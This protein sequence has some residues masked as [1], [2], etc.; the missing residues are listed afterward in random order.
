MSGRTGSAVIRRRRGRGRLV[1][2]T[3]FVGVAATAG[4]S[5]E[6]RC[7]QNRYVAAGTYERCQ[8]KAEGKYHG[9]GGIDVPRYQES[10]RKCGVVYARMLQRLQG[11]ALG[12][13]S[14]CDGARLVDNGD[15]TVTD[16][17]TGLQWE[18]KTDDASVHDRDDRHLWSAGGA[19]AAGIA[20][21]SFLAA[22]NG[23]CF[24]GHCDRRLPTLN[25]LQTIL[26]AQYPDGDL[27][28]VFGPRGDY[29]WTSTAH[30]TTPDLAWALSFQDGSRTT[31]T[32]D[33]TLY[34]RAVR[35]G[36]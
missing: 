29:Y 27:D 36:L 11:R 24:A 12:T 19:A 23:A 16:E 4:A 13:G 14:T 31:F 8:R 5:P 32:K 30:A 26:L 35:G 22:L 21:T 2:A 34:V 18:K 20:F 10:A 25:E 15:G 6:T 1:V 9:A 7:Q 3:L 28:P 33:A 17:L